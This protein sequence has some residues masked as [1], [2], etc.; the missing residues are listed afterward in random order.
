VTVTSLFAT[1]GADSEPFDRLVRWLDRWLAVHGECID[2]Y[3]EVGASCPPGWFGWTEHLESD[4][5]ELAMRAADVVV[6]DGSP[7]S[8]TLCT[9]VGRTPIVV[10]R[11]ARLGEA[12]D[13]R[14]VM[15]CRHLAGSGR[16]WLAE[17]EDRFASLLTVALDP[18]ATRLIVS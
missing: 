5:R 17:D 14:E 12:A 6:C 10:P 9:F 16:I 13:E 15:H 2:A 1:V 3:L 8:M 7:V 18:V 11:S 4:E